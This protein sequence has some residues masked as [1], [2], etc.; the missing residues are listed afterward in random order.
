MRVLLCERALSGHRG[1]YLKCLSEISGNIYCFAPDNVGVSESNFIRYRPNSKY[2]EFWEYYF[3]LS[4]I[5]K[6]IEEKSIDI[7]HILD[8]D[9]IMRYMGVGFS[10]FKQVK[11]IIT[12]HH[13]FSDFKHKF[14]Y[15]MMLKHKNRLGVVHSKVLKERFDKIGIK[16]ISVIKYPVFDMSCF[17]NCNNEHAKKKWGLK[18]TY[19]VIGIIGG[20]AMY[21]G[22]D[23]FLEALVKVPKKYQ[24]LVCGSKSD[25]DVESIKKLVTELGVEN[26]IYLKK[27]T[28]TEYQDAIAASDIIYCIY[29]KKFD[30]ASGILTDGVSARKM[31]LACDHGTLGQVVKKH[32]LG[33]VVDSDNKEEIT[34]NT[35]GAIAACRNFSYDDIAETYRNSLSPE[36]FKERYLSMYNSVLV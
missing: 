24:L 33:Y 1:K 15:K 11:L 12:F 19:P 5:E 23:K 32:H 22:I 13:Y 26:S 35:I 18:G 34:L 17:A 10:R 29:T 14:S 2:G 25:A 8:G 27:M 21:K 16:N 9:S 20:I 31:I 28:D 3:W 6:I 4:D 36:L 30:G 7:V